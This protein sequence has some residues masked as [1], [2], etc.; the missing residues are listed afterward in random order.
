MP[1]DRSQLLKLRPLAREKVAVPEWGGDVFIRAMTGA[2]RDEFEQEY[3]AAKKGSGDYIPNLRARLLVRTVCDEQGKSLLTT[4]D[5][6]AL[7]AQSADIVSRLY[8]V[9]SRLNGLS[10]ADREELEKN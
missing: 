2:E 5:I 3:M 4:N 7:G 1:L 8:N 10:K 6:D 9:A